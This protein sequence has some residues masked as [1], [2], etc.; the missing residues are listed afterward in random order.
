MRFLLRSRST[1]PAA[2]LG[3][4]VSFAAAPV[5][6][7]PV[8]RQLNATKA[9]VFHDSIGVCT[10]FSFDGSIYDQYTNDIAW[11]LKNLGVKWVR[12]GVFNQTDVNKLK[13]VNSKSGVKFLL[14][15]AMYGGDGR[16]DPGQAARNA[17]LM[18][19]LRGKLVGIEGPNEYDQFKPGNEPDWAGRLRQYQ[20]R[21]FTEV[22]KRRGIR[23]VR[24]LAP[25]LVSSRGSYAALG[26]IT[27]DCD[28]ANFHYY[29][30]VP[31]WEI[32]AKRDE[33]RISK[34]NGQIWCTEF[35]WRTPPVDYYVSEQIQA[36]YAL[37]GYAELFRR[38]VRR[39]SLYALY[40]H[41]TN[42]GFESG[43]RWGLLKRDG[44]Q[45]PS[46][47]AIRR[48]INLIR[49]SRYNFTAGKLD[50]TIDT[51]GK[52]VRQLA[53][54]HSDGRRFLFLY[55]PIDVWDYQAKK[56]KPFSYV[57][58]RVKVHTPHSQV[59]EH[60]PNNGTVKTVSTDTTYG[61]GDRVVILEIKP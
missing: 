48:M 24:I 2:V 37:R 21:L 45:K 40:D 26:N 8:R 57:S 30:G 42:G 50:Y 15:S 36:R 43:Q 56:S 49:D 52:D 7:E 10:K 55:R 41:P 46:Y 20:D 34:P 54:R 29:P 60:I 28:A 6:A 12:D 44:T 38:G 23:N 33:A 47:Q 39:S 14:I 18:N 9:A 32:V 11:Y 1:V 17:D 13:T 19:Q 35:G 25:S 31:E 53:L 5:R 58:V 4:L 51:F 59:R 3:L 22:N 27:N 16:L 61:I